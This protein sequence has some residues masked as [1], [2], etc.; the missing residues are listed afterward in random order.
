MILWIDPWIKKLWYAVIE[1]NLQILEAWALV[2]DTQNMKKREEQYQRMNEI[3]DF[4]QEIYK[5][6]PEIKVVS[7][8]R[9]F[10]TTFNKSNAEFIYGV[11]GILLADALKKD[12]K[13]IE[14]TP[15]ELK[16]N[17]TGNAKANKET[18]QKFIDKYFQ[19]KDT[20]EYHDV[21]DALGLAFLGRIK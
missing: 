19:L 13:I 15:Q 7:M 21:S 8:E 20:P 2:L 4:F 11:R 3:F 17:I 6:Y 18:I 10:F 9:Y 14:Y 12:K 5:K 16:K 1:N